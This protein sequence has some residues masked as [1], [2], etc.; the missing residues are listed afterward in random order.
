MRRTLFAIFLAAAA[1]ASG[2]A[3]QD[4]ADAPIEATSLFG[5]PLTRQLFDDATRLRLEANL[6]A[7]RERYEAAPHDEDAIIWYAR[8]LG[9]LGRFQEAIDVLNKGLEEQPW[10]FRMLRHRGHRYISMREFDKAI[11]DLAKADQQFQTRD[12]IEPDGAPNRLG[13]PRSTTRFNILYH[14]GLAH[15]L[16]GDFEGAHDAWSRCMAAARR[17]D[18]MTIATTNWL[19]LTCLRLGRDDEARALLEPIHDDMNI[20]EES[21]YLALCL[22]HKGEISE[23]EAL[24]M[25]GAEANPSLPGINNAT[26]GYGVGMHRMLSGDDAG[27]REMFSRVLDGPSWGAFGY[28]AAEAEQA[29]LM[30]VT[31]GSR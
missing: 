3:R 24:R 13:L 27:A 31:G 7:A 2:A 9:Y 26:V 12:E 11:A 5:T 4:A 14:L 15:Y 28:I 19:A 30:R 21:T 16:K 20:V 25:A 17:N 22:L 10:S 1:C 29:R 23:D 8:R 18:D 6:G